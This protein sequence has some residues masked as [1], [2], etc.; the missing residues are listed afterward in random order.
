MKKSYKALGAA[1]NAEIEIIPAAEA[2]ALLSNEEGCFIDIRD[3][4][5]L[6]LN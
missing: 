2:I 4:A 5:E 1:A 3:S 6:A